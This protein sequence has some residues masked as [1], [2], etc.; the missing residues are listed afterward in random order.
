M[1]EVHSCLHIVY[2]FYIEIL[3]IHYTCVW[4]G[5]FQH[6]SQQKS[7]PGFSWSTVC[8]G[9]LMFGSASRQ[10]SAY[11]H[12]KAPIPAGLRRTERSGPKPTSRT[13]SPIG[14]EKLREEDV[15]ILYFLTT[16]R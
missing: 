3:S 6:L 9:E 8:R 1:T 16:K 2:L 10:N 14:E 4:R 7:T 11:W 5:I 13:W 12:M 15:R